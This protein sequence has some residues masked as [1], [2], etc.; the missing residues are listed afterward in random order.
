MLQP[1][2]YKFI[3]NE[4]YIVMNTQDQNVLIQSSSDMLKTCLNSS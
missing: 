2:I 1:Q 4:K 3:A